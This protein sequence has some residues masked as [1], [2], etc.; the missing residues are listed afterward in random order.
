MATQSAS[1]SFFPALAPRASAQSL[2]NFFT[3]YK[4]TRYAYIWRVAEE[5]NPIPFPRTWFSRPVAGPTPLHYYPRDATLMRLVFVFLS[6]H[7]TYCAAIYSALLSASRAFCT[8]SSL[9]ITSSEVI[10]IS[11]LC[12][13]DWISSVVRKSLYTAVI[14]F[15]DHLRSNCS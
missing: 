5:S 12:N 15:S 2:H 11:L 6:T 9:V 8:L 3:I 10:Q 13:I 4:H 1:L 7:N 14:K